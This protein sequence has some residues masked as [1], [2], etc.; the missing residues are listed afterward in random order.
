[1]KCLLH[2]G[3]IVKGSSRS[4][5]AAAWLSN[6]CVGEGESPARVK[7][8]PVHLE[9]CGS[10]DAQQV[11]ELDELLQGVD[12]AF[13]CAGTERQEEATI[14]FM[15]NGA[16]ETIRAARR[17][18][19][20]SV[21][22]TSSGGS[23]NPPGLVNETPK[24]EIEHWSDPA[25]Q[26]SNGRWS[27]AAKTLMELGS[28][29]EVGRNKNNVIEDASLAQTSPRL[30]IVN[31]NLILGPQ[32]KPGALSGNSLP[33]VLSILKG[34]RM[35][36]VI[37]NDSMSIIDVRDLAAFHVAC[38]ERPEASGRYFGVNRSFSWE[39]I[40]TEFKAAYPAYAVPVRFDGPSKT[41]TQFDFA[42][43]DSLQVP[44]RALSETV[45]DLVAFFKERGELP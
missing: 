25:M 3:Y 29:R 14:P 1:V 40:L 27:P 6:L 30:S 8:Y 42:R 24:N 18:G 17:Q 19:V 43:R 13:F 35:H 16:L 32:L 44:L 12:A 39:E 26:K 5:E 37:P 9:R 15:V 33:W 7:L 36:E 28:L 22:I 2:K 31:P 11:G 45:E 20:K 34:E 21:V 41:P 4:P 38:A 10:T 23:T